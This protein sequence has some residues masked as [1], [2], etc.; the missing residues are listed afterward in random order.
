MNTHIITYHADKALQSKHASLV[1]RGANGGLAGSDV[2]ILSKS[3]RQCNVNSFHQDVLQDLDIVQCAALIQTQHGIVN[4]ILIEYAYSGQGPTIHTTGQ[5]EWYNNFVDGKSTQVGGKQVIITYDGY[6]IP[7]V[8]REGLMYL[9][10]IGKPTIDDLTKYP[11]VHLTCPHPWD[12]TMLDA[13]N[14]H[15][16]LTTD[17]GE[18]GSPNGA[19]EG[20]QSKILST[21]APHGFFRSRC[22]QDPSA[23]KPMF[24]FDPCH[25]SYDLFFSPPQENGEQITGKDNKVLTTNCTVE[26]QN[27]S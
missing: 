17:G 1:N 26:I 25:K 10:F 14:P 9:E 13:P 22:D 15:H 5:I 20:S 24:E 11:S 6:I 2:T 27:Q 19:S 4:L 21:R 7:L 16:S 12:P 8:S 3:L 18:N 23:V